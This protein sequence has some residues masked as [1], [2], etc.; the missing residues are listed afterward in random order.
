M[1]VKNI[2][3]SP[4]YYSFFFPSSSWY[5]EMQNICLQHL[6]PCDVES[7]GSLF[8]QSLPGPPLVS[9][10]ACLQDEP[11]LPWAPGAEP[12]ASGQA[13]Q[14]VFLLASQGEPDLCLKFLLQ[15]MVRMGAGDVLKSVVWREALQCC[16]HVVSFRM[17]Q[18]EDA[19][20]KVYHYPSSTFYTE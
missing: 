5:K 2:F 8:G 17:T 19:H 12:Q 9:P 18:L 7:Q 10:T 15:S 1:N 4:F 3:F 16:G 6:T 11:V 20:L 14:S 13:L